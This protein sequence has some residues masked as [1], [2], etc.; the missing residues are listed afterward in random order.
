MYLNLTYLEI[1]ENSPHRD[2]EV[3]LGVYCDLGVTCY[4]SNATGTAA[5]L[6]LEN[7]SQSI[8]DIV[9]KSKQINAK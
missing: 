5:A 7:N 6:L 1:H 9:S 4:V 8:A 3:C 2:A